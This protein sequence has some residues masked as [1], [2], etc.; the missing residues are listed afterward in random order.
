MIKF[1]VFA[2]LLLN[3]ITIVSQSSALASDSLLGVS[4]QDVKY[5]KTASEF[6]TCKD[7]SKKIRADQLNDDFCDCPDGS[8]EPGTSACPNGK[9]YCL[10]AG[11]IPLV[12]FS[13]RVNDGI[14]DCCDGSDE[15]DGKLKCPN[16]CWEAGKVARDKLQK[17]IVTYQKGVAVRKKEVEQAKSSFTKD[18][19]ELSDL[20][21]EEKILKGLVDDLKARKEQI[22]KA[23]E[24]ERLEKERLEKDKEQKNKNE[25]GKEANEEATDD[26]EI[27]IGKEES[28]SKTHDDSIGN[29]D[30]S[31]E[32]D[33]EDGDANSEFM[34]EDKELLS[35][36]VDPHVEKEEEDEDSAP[37]SES[38][39]H[40]NHNEKGE[41][42]GEDETL[43]KEDLGRLV[44][45]RWTGENAGEKTRESDT[46][47]DDDSPG[48]IPKDIEEYDGYTSDTYDDDERY[49]DHDSG[50]TINDDFTE[51]HDDSSSSY[52]SD[53]EDE[54]NL[55]DSTSWI[56][57]IKK[58]VGSILEAVNPFQT[59]VNISDASRVRKEFDEYTTKLSKVQ[60]K[61][62]SLSKKLKHDFGPDKEFYS[63]YDRCFESKESKYVYKICPYKQATQKDGHSTTRLGEWENFEESYKVMLFSNGDK[64]WNG[65]DRSLKVRLRCG[66]D[67]E[68]ADV[69]EPSRCE[70][71][72]VLATPNVCYEE[73]L[74]EL[75]SKL[76]KMNN[77]QPQD[78]DEL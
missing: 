4:P 2:S 9:F 37:M 52:K 3:F 55:P 64:C 65:P 33:M 19:A 28:N 51:D 54:T 48:D 26:S 44:A 29:I 35:D 43:S 45:S 5:Y 77:Q 24:K 27:E 30:Q 11:H 73:K 1:L 41:I 8:D 71:V 39:T 32:Q 47:K 14:C 21:N 13:S 60:S 12:L 78:H 53:S 20:K 16:T 72:A 10:N 58:T 42:S 62:S 49:D 50:D 57:K 46:S 59:P 67:N 63:F 61:L 76:E 38:G 17:K 56:K 31:K 34:E 75:Q 66:L 6:V 74:K 25:S 40:P 18:E 69:D 7:G 68:I 22:E 15:Y 36:A 70:Y 23:E